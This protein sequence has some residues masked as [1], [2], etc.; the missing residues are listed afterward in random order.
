MWS[1]LMKWKLSR[2]KSRPTLLTLI[3]SNPEA[4]VLR[5]TTD[6]LKTV[7]DA[8]DDL[9]C[10]LLALGD[11]C[12]MKGVGAATASGVCFVCVGALC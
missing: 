10:A 12:N 3:A 7:R 8:K 11:A 1:A 2:G 9:H 5:S 4:L 6:A